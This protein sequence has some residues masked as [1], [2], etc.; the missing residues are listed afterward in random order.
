MQQGYG[1]D[2]LRSFD[3]VRG[4]VDMSFTYTYLPVLQLVSDD[5]GFLG[6]S[7]YANALYLVENY[8]KRTPC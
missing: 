6:F 2:D 4:L 3:R 8:A 7:H 5:A 1:I